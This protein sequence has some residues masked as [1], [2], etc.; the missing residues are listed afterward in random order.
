MK[1]ASL[2][3]AI[4]S[5][6]AGA[7][8]TDNS[9][10]TRD[11]K[12]GWARQMVSKYDWGILGTISTM[13]GLEG[14]PFGNPNSIAEVDGQPYFYVSSLDQS[15]QDI[16]SDAHVS[17]ALSDA[18]DLASTACGTIAGDPESPLCSRLTISGTFLN[19]S[20]TSEADEAWTALTAK[21]PAMATWPSDHSWFIGKIQI[22]HLWL[23]NF[24]GGATNIT[25]DEYYSYAAPELD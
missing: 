15:I 24:Y 6:A 16:Q 14:T 20:G 25:P 8:A 21:H 2:S 12:V 22:S 1:C 5:L 3:V 10:V 23:I 9:T 17:L 7:A 4:F 11:D 18:E 13:A 19:I